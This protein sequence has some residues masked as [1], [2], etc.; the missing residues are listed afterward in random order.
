MTQKLLPSLTLFFPAYYDENTIEELTLRSID[1]AKQLTDNYEILIIDDHSPDRTGEIADR[2]AAQHP[3]VKAIH[4]DKNRGV[5]QAMITGYTNASKEYVF[6]T[7]GDA[8]YDVSELS[9][10]A[11]HA[12]NYDLVAGYRLKRAEGLSRALIS[13]S[14]NVLIFLFFGV[15]YK[16]IDCSFKLI[17]RNFL[18]RFHFHADSG[19]VDAEIL[20]RAKQLKI[21]VKEIGVTHYPRR[22]GSSRCL[23][24]G[25]GLQ[26][27]RDMVALRF[28]RQAH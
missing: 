5:G 12:G 6:Y 19:F 18:E 26:I 24:T 16:D 13:R 21:P 27:L 28:R 17:R 4:H 11:E 2:L 1:A 14:F 20:I 7:D 23:K 22:F 8:Q 3:E 9:K 10:L 15:Y 25:L